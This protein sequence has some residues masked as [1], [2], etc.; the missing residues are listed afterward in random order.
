MK[1]SAANILEKICLSLPAPCIAGFSNERDGAGY[2]LTGAVTSYFDQRFGYFHSISSCTDKFGIGSSLQ[3]IKAFNFS[4]T[5]PQ[6]IYA[7]YRGD[8]EYFLVKIRFV[9]STRGGLLNFLSFYPIDLKT[10]TLLLAKQSAGVGQSEYFNWLRSL[11]DLVRRNS[12][13]INAAANLSVI[14]L[15]YGSPEF[16][17]LMLEKIISKGIVQKNAFFMFQVEQDGILAKESI[18]AEKLELIDA[19]KAV[20]EFLTDDRPGQWSASLSALIDGEYF[21]KIAKVNFLER[22]RLS[23]F[24]VPCNEAGPDPVLGAILSTSM[25]SYCEYL[26]SQCANDETESADRVELKRM[27]FLS[28]LICLLS[29]SIANENVAPIDDPVVLYCALELL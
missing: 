14:Y 25:R 17:L 5:Y 15:N 4:A 27:R 1:N 28:A 23:Q 11:W 7:L 6:Y 9:D 20:V 13:N 24:L 19:T 16:L 29:E 10:I 2:A 22:I 12:Y 3:T 26:S 8:A 18:P 21:Q